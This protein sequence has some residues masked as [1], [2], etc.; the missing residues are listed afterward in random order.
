MQLD[1]AKLLLDGGAIPKSALEVAQVAED[2]A[3]V[4]LETTEERLKVL[5]SDPQH[6]DGIVDVWPLPFPE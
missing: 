2:N 3:K 5:G 6:P 4:D 1:R